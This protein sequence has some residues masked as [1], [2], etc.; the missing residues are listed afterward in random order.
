MMG[1]IDLRTA[2]RDEPLK[3]RQ[4]QV[5]FEPGLD[6]VVAS[7]GTDQQ[8]ISMAREPDPDTLG[9]ATFVDPSAQSAYA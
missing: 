8:D 6:R 2:P 3:S 5:V 7:D 9:G 4:S 1:P